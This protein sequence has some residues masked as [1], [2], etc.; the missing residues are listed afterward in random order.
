MSIPH[1]SR[2]IVLNTYEANPIP[3]PQLDYSDAMIWSL[4]AD[5]LAVSEDGR[6]TASVTRNELESCI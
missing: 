4:E 6:E 2:H 3:M 5:F 1:A